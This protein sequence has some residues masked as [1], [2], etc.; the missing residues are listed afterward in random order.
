MSNLWGQILAAVLGLA[1]G[2]ILLY[3][4]G[5]WKNRDQAKAKASEKADMRALLTDSVPALTQKVDTN[6]S[7]HTVLLEALQSNFEQHRAEDR[8]GLAATNANVASSC[9]RVMGEIGKL[10]GGVARLI[11]TVEGH[12]G[13]L[14]RIETDIREL[15]SNTTS[16]LSEHQARIAVLES[17][18]KARKNTTEK[19]D[20]NA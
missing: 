11:G 8:A 12:D 5:L 6:H 7:E 18:T 16:L 4:A 20:T 14:G 13:R 9:D 10:T 2:V 1:S 3:V 19:E 17:V 15:N